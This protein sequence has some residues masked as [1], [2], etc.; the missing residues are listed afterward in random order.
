MK[1]L[2]TLGAVAIAALMLL[3]KK[4]AAE[5]IQ[6]TP[7]DIAIDT[8]KTSQ[9]YWAKIFYRVKLRLTNN[10]PAAVKVSAVNL[11][12]AVNGIGLGS[13]NN[14][15]GFTVNANSTQDI[16]IDASLSSVGAINI[17]KDILMNG[18]S[19]NILVTGYVTTDLG[20]VDVT[21]TKNL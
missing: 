5:N 9:V 21:F 18:M 15:S 11:N 8:E 19:L 2:L 17:I 6:V 14:T 1:N 7:L 20:R 4:R 12:V 3:R 10:E 13:I 16:N